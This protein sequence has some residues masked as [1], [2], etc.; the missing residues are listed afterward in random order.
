MMDNHQI[1]KVVIIEIKP[2]DA[3]VQSEQYSRPTT[4]KNVWIQLF[5]VVRT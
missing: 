2:G 3:V 4:L 1:K 5:L